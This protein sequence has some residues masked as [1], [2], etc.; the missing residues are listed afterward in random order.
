MT[1]RRRWRSLDLKEKLLWH[2]SWRAWMLTGT[3]KHYVPKGAWQ[4]QTI[5]I[6]F[7]LLEK[8]SSSTNP[9][10]WNSNRHWWSLQ[11]SSAV[12]ISWIT[13]LIR[14]V[15]LLYPNIYSWVTMSAGVAIQLTHLAFCSYIR[16]NI[17]RKSTCCVEGKNVPASQGSMAFMMNAKGNSAF[18][19]GKPS[20]RFLTPCRFVLWFRN[21]SSVFHQDYPHT[22]KVLTNCVPFVGRMMYQMLDSFAIC[23]GPTLTRMSLFGS[24]L[25]KQSNGHLVLM[26]WKSFWT[27]IIWKGFTVRRG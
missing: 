18:E 2:L 8:R 10:C 21:V 27:I 5:S 3:L 26:C 23:F 14:L 25:I 7:V 9:L 4:K 12:L 11:I 19:L 20:L 16:R 22:C 13:Y 15:S 17:L 24:T 6:F 1:T